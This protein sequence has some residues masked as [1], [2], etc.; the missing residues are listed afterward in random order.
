MAAA[1]HERVG[2]F[3]VRWR[4][5]MRVASMGWL[6]AHVRERPVRTAAATFADLPC[7]ADM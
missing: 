1:T 4:E 6:E 5:R 3:N 7:I 2:A